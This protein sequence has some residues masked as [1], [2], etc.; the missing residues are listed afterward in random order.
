MR[1]DIITY[2]RNNDQ[3]AYDE[4]VEKIRSHKPESQIINEKFE[5]IIEKFKA[6]PDHKTSKFDRQF[7]L[8]PSVIR[9][10]IKK[11]IALSDN[12]EL[13]INGEVA[14]FRKKIVPASDELGKYLKIYS[15]A[16][17]E[18]FGGEREDKL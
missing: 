13:R 9:A 15:D 2:F 6:L 12:I 14:D 16:G 17:Y 10:R 1:N 7:E 8:E 4:I 11:T 3:F 18:E 5:N